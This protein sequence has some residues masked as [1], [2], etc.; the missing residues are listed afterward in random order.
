MYNYIYSGSANKKLDNTSF[1]FY[2]KKPPHEM[3]LGKVRCKIR[4][5]NIVAYG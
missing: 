4:I 3:S 5:E 2:A 1:F